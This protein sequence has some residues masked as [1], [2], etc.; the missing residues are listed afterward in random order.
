MEF[1][2]F[3]F[4]LYYE[5]DDIA[6]VENLII[7]LKEIDHVQIGRIHK[8]PVGPHPIGSCQ[9]TVFKENYYEMTEWFLNNRDGI[10]LFIHPVSG[11]DL[12]DHTDFAMW[13][14]KSYELNLD[15]FKS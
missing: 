14:G 1:N 11:E 12:I 3:H 8:K 5:L 7:K 4:H 15:I 2:K 6:K 13:I 9:I 10:D